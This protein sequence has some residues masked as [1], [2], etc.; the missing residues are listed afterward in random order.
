[1]PS[2]IGP[3]LLFA[4]STVPGG[5][6]QAALGLAFGAVVGFSLGLTGGGGSIFAVPL[7]V[8][9]LAVGPERRSASRW[10][11]WGRPPSSAGC[12]RL[13]RARSRSAP[14]C[15]SPPPGCSGRRRA[16]GWADGSPRTCCWSSSP[17]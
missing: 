15:S 2:L 1:M 11:P 6:M 12:E 16:R 5:G 4:D 14:G 9:G 7:L 17:P 10:P 13:A 3:L 8:Y